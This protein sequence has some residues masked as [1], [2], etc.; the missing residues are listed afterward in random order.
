VTVDVAPAR[1]ARPAAAPTIV[2]ARGRVR[3]ALARPLVMSL[4]LLLL[5]GGCSLLNDPR[6]FLGTDTGGKVATLR[7]MDSRGDLDPD[8]GYW[9]ERFDP[10][11]VAHPIA[12]NTRIGDRWVNVTTLPMVYAAVPLYELGGL[13]GILLLPMIGG[14]LTALAAR[15][16][17]Q[18]LGAS[19]TPAFWLVGLATPVA[20]Y[21]LDFWEHTLGTAA[22]LWAV[23]LMLDAAGATR[24]ARAPWVLAAA[25]AALFGVAA[26]MR[27]EALVYAVVTFA[28]VGVI[29]LRDRRPDVLRIGAASAVGLVVPLLANH[30]LET[31]VLGSGLRAGRA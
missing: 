20:V 11:G 29:L 26:T 13:R 19:G 8:L 5:Y 25:G 4:L 1:T 16:L 28:V 22:M 2:P 3:V 14:V 7:A 15:A 31:L 12:L 17:A 6:A 10:D 27:T 18:R 24:R 23:V 9:A 21:A 30:F